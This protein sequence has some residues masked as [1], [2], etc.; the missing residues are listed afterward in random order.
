MQIVTKE[1]C[2]PCVTLKNMLNKLNVS[3]NECGIDDVPE[4][5][6]WSISGYPAVFMGT[7]LLF[8]GSPGS[9]ENLKN[10]LTRVGVI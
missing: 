6:K 2:N 4:N 8:S 1:N 9:I 3:Y 5:I 7:N 10:L